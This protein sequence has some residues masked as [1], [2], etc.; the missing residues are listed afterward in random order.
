MKKRFSEELISVFQ[1][2]GC[3]PACGGVVPQAWFFRSAC[4]CACALPIPPVHPLDIDAPAF[5]SEQNVDASIAKAPTLPGKR[6]NALM[7]EVEI[8]IS[9]QAR[10][11]DN[12]HAVF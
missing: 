9:P 2:S 4:D 6:N 5:A 8:F 10:R 1:G 3:E 11:S 12:C 7:S